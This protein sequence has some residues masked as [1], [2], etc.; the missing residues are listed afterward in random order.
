MRT[1]LGVPTRDCTSGYRG[2]TRSGLE[3]IDPETL[4]SKGPEIIAEVLFRADRRGLRIREQPITFQDRTA[5]ESKIGLRELQGC[6]RAVFGLRW[7]D[8]RGH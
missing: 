1:L 3:R 6:L 7:R 2:F 4:A 8:M 5:G